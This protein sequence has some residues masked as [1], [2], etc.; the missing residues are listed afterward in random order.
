MKNNENPF[1]WQLP[2][3][4]R[5]ERL[6]SKIRHMEC[7]SGWEALLTALFNKLEAYEETKKNDEAYE[8]VYFVQIKEKFGGLRAYHEGGDVVTQGYVTDAEDASYRT[9]DNC[10]ATTPDVKTRYTKH[11]WL[12]VSCNS[13]CKESP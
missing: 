2:I 6:L 12:Y 9:C 1:A 3:F 11:Q 10:G 4:T 8:P 13:C 5:Y 7:S